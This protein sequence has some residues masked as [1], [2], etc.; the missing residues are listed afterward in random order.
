MGEASLTSLN[1]DLKM[2]VESEAVTSLIKENTS[3]I[4]PRIIFKSRC[5]PR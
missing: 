4:H 2:M 5:F 3:T 1:P